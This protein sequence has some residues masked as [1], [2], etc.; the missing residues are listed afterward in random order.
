[1]DQSVHELVSEKL[2]EIFIDI[3]SSDNQTVDANS[4]TKS[5][6]DNKVVYVTAKGKDNLDDRAF[7]FIDDKQKSDG[8]Q[9]R[10]I[11]ASNIRFNLPNLLRASGSG[12][13]AIAGS[14][15]S[16]TLL[17]TSIL[18]LI[19]DLSN[20][21]TVKLSKPTAYVLM[22]IWNLR[23]SEPNLNAILI[24]ANS[25]CEQDDQDLLSEKKLLKSLKIL[26]DYG[27]ISLED[28]KYRISETV[29][30]KK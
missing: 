9:A 16:P 19:A 1:M 10:S 15:S 24:E 4:F 18:L 11:K 21:A 6:F 26:M 14:L 30:V 2:E 22:A 7:I 29:H 25:L 12:I 27:C 28:D 23:Y 5:L 20:A 13:L 8:I 3:S 17:V